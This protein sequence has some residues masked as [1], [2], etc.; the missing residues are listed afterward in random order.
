MASLTLGFALLLCL[1]NA[2]LWT[3][4]TEMPLA[5]V[6]WIAAAGS[7]MWLQRWQKR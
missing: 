1:L 7:C 4:Y 6:G 2:G 5:S 3:V